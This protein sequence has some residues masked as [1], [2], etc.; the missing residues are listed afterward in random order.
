MRPAPPG[1]PPSSQDSFHASGNEPIWTGPGRASRSR[2]QSGAGRFRAVWIGAV[3]V[4]LG[5]IAGFIVVLLNRGG[6]PRTSASASSSTPSAGPRVPLVLRLSRTSSVTTAKRNPD[7]ASNA[8]AGIQTTLSAFYDAAFMDPKTRKD[9]PPDAWNAFA[10]SLRK[11]AREDAVSLT[12]GDTGQ[13]IK[14]LSV[15]QAGLSVRLLLDPKGRPQAAVAT[16][17]FDASGTLTGGEQVI[18]SN[19][20]RFLLRPFG[21]DW[22][23]VGYPSAETS[24]ESPPA[25]PS[26]SSSASPSSGATP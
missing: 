10:E 21:K 13:S 6:G 3:I 9:L 5:L 22:L 16:V 24:V 23:V 26:S 14:S 15:S 1:E 20:A 12:L 2:G 25:S 11:R 17:V 7:A 19:R 4:L 8:A 18:V